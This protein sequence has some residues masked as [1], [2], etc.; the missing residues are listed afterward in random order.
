MA[1]PRHLSAAAATT[2]S[3]VP[4]IPYEEIDARSA[5]SGGD[6]AGDIAV[7]QQDETRAPIFRTRSMISSCRGRSRIIIVTSV[8]NMRFARAIF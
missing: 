8:T 1:P 7:G 4:P 2:P 3:G 6:G 5:P